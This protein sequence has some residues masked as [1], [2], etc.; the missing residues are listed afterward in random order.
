MAK[1]SRHS[2]NPSGTMI[3]FSRMNIGASPLPHDAAREKQKKRN[4]ERILKEPHHRA[5]QLIIKGTSTY[6]PTAECVR[7]CRMRVGAVFACA[8]KYGHVVPMCGAVRKSAHTGILVRIC[9][10]GAFG[11]GSAKNCGLCLRSRI[12][13]NDEHD[14]HR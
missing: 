6:S 7:L 14:R 8:P 9:I 13:R 2:L 10:V 12:G 5:V 11:G 3:A 1:D 4:E